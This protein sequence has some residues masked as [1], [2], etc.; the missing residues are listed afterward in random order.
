MPKVAR[1]R[2]SALPRVNRTSQVG[3]E[4]GELLTLPL[5]TCLHRRATEQIPLL[6]NKART[7]DN[8]KSVKIMKD[9]LILLEKGNTCAVR[10]CFAMSDVVFRKLMR[11]QNWRLCPCLFSLQRG[12]QCVLWMPINPVMVRLL[13]CPP[14]WWLAGLTGWLSCA[15]R[16]FN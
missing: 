2:L 12:G 1:A 5:F 15:C 3:R 11:N 7:N 14:P 9:C 6:Q 16:C 8:M 10:S 4:Q 13:S